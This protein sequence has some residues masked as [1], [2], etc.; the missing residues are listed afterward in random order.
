MDSSLVVPLGLGLIGVVTV[1]MLLQ[2][3]HYNY[4]PGPK[5]LPVLGNVLD[6]P[7][8]EW[9]VKYRD[10]SRE[11]SEPRFPQPVNCGAECCA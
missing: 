1:Y 10:W 11:Y 3:K 6:L 9:W 4:P 8:K 7:K 2:K 5:G